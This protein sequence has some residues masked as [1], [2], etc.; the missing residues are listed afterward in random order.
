MCI[1]VPSKVLSVSDDGVSATV[2][3]RGEPLVINLMMLEDEVFVGDYLIIQ[4]GGFAVEKMAADEAKK[5]IALI[6]AL[7]VGDMQRATK[8]Y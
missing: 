5:A 1:G 6:N 7:E 3:T 8:L 4:V 2:E